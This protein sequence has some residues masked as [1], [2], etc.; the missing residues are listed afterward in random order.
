MAQ[1]G[2]GVFASNFS[3][4]QAVVLVVF[5]LDQIFMQGSSKAGPATA[6]IKFVQG[7]K[8]G[9]AADNVH[10]NPLSGFIPVFILKGGF[11]AVLLGHMVLD[12]REL[13]LQ[14]AFI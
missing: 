3:A 14:I 6:G 11:G 5:F 1:M 7:C 9:L 12:F 13:F 4:Y 8:Q 2:I 10:V